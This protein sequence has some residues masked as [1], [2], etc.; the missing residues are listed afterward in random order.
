EH[1]FTVQ[2]EITSSVASAIRPAVSDAE[3]RRAMFRSHE[4]LGAWDLYQQGMWHLAKLTSAENDTAR[5]L[6]EG[7][8]KIDPMFARAY[9]GLARAIISAGTV[10]YDMPMDEA[11]Q[12]T[13]MHAHKAIELDASDADAHAIWAIVLFQQGDAGTAQA[14]AEQALAINPS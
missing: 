1:V 6:F 8:I 13:S 4:S 10:F 9:V 5:S 2:D 7:A 3:M 14:I 11:L 12:A